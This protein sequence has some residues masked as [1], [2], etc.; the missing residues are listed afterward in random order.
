MKMT[1][2]TLSAFLDDELPAAEMD[3]VRRQLISD[4]VLASRLAELAAVDSLLQARF[5]EIDNRPLPTAITEM[6]ERGAPRNTA[7]TD[8]RVVA[9][10]WRR[11]TRGPAVK[12]VAAVFIGAVAMVQ[13]LGLPSVDE[14]GWGEVADI[15]DNQ[16]GGVS[17]QV[18]DEASLTP[19]LTFQNQS[20]D[21]CRHFRLQ[22]QSSAT[23]QIACRDQGGSWR[24]EERVA[25]EKALPAER[26][27]TA[28]ARRALDPALDR[29][30]VGEPVGPEKERQLL[31]EHWS[32]PSRQ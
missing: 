13:W 30:M 14:P 2:E 16:P 25:V 7:S 18:G 5:G 29:M 10:P 6:L 17:Y 21:W 22:T 24:R 12:A 19:Q 3:V 11:I 1:D 31:K 26:Y 32:G 15:L 8:A 27:Q 9:F 4:P 28:T 20:G 23:E